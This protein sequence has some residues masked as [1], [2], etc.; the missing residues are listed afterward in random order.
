MERQELKYTEITVLTHHQAVEGVADVLRCLGAR[1]VV[2]EE[3]GGGTLVTAYL[4]SPGDLEQQ[5]VMVR[6]RLSALER[7]GICIA[8][9][10]V[11]LRDLDARVWCEAWQDHFQVLHITPRLVVVPSWEKYQPAAGECVV[12]LEPGAAF[13]TGGHETTRLCLRGLVEH[14]RPGDRVAD[15]GCGSGILAVSAAVLGAREVVATDSDRS[16]LAVALANAR[17]NGVE[18]RIQFLEADLLPHSGGP[19]DLIVCNIVS[20]EVIR[21]AERLSALLSPGGRFIGSGF[22]A[23]MIPTVEEALLRAGLEMVEVLDHEGW[24]ACVG[25][26]PATT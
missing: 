5:V 9:G 7:E 24:T 23:N 3:R 20:Q 13:G 22:L 16:A 14:M 18:D 19:F 8:P 6:A 26:R 17:R 21:L 15:V 2:E 10:T 12:V 4:A 1:G 25:A 11:G